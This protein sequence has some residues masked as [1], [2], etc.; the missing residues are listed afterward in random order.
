MRS[1]G[2]GELE[3]VCKCVGMTHRS[4]EVGDHAG[5]GIAEGHIELAE[6]GATTLLTQ[7]GLTRNYWSYA[8]ECYAMA[9]KY[10]SAQ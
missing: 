1:D 8:L 3:A 6:L 10:Y 4:I 5:D 9:W 7:A 2:S